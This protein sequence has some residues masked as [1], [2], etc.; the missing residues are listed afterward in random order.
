MFY[1]IFA[2]F[3]VVTGTARPMPAR[4]A[5]FGIR[6]RDA[7]VADRALLEMIYASTR[8]QEVATTGWPEAQQRDFLQMQFAAQHNYYQAN[9]PD[10]LWLIIECDGDP[11][12]RLFLEDW[13]GELRI[14]DIAL[15]PS[16]RRQG[17]G[18]AILHD[19]MDRT[20]ATGRAVSIHVEK[21]N[22][23]MSLY[24]RLGFETVEDKGVYDLLEW[25]P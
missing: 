25:R 2:A 18:E 10:A 4:A 11:A 9:Y 24:R 17:I 5:P 23:A 20:A 14:I 21:T 7:T 12:G 22:P 13:S 3:V 1:D 15:L 19:L 16:Y 6:Y 8:A